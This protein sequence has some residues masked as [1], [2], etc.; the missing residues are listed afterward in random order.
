[1]LRACA[2][3]VQPRAL[4]LLAIRTNFSERSASDRH[5]GN[6]STTAVGANRRVNTMNNDKAIATSAAM[7]AIAAVASGALFFSAQTGAS[8]QLPA[9][10]VPQPQVVVEYVDAAGN[11]MPIEPTAEPIAAN[12][13]TV[14][15]APQ[16]REEED[17]DDEDEDDD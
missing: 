16:Y 1:M 7:V 11:V 13:T 9:Q 3:G 14:E 2:A 15:P 4:R 10:P 5:C 8:N 12:P 17:E 6:H